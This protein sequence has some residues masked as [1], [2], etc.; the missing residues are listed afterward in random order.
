MNAFIALVWYH[1]IPFHNFEHACHVTTS[2][3]KH[4]K[5]IIALDLFRAAIEVI[6]QQGKEQMV[7]TSFPESILIQWLSL[8]S[9][10]QVLSMMSK[11]FV[12]LI[13]N[14]QKKSPLCQKCT[15]TKVWPSKLLVDVM[16]V[17]PWVESEQS[18]RLLGSTGICFIAEPDNVR[19]HF[20]RD[21][22]IKL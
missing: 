9:L 19:T 4:I 12:C 3:N 15:A 13:L 18:Q 1:N 10:F 20:R 6:A 8:M 22:S 17:I 16:F 21:F 14:R 11:I 7:M 2:I 5:R